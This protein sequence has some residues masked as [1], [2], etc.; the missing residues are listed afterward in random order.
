MKFINLL[1]KSTLKSLSAIGILLLVILF[2]SQGELKAQE[3]APLSPAERFVVQHIQKGKEANLEEFSKKSQDHILR[4][5]FV[6]NVLAGDYKLGGPI[7]RIEHAIVNDPLNAPSEDIPFAVWMTDC[8]FRSGVDFSDAKFAN[9]L[10]FEGSTFGSIQAHSQTSEQR[11]SDTQALF[12]GMHVSGSVVLS[13]AKFYVPLDF[14]YAQI[15]GQLLFDDVLFQAPGYADFYGLTTTYAP[16]FFRH[17]HF[18]GPLALT[19]ASLFELFLE[20]ITFDLSGFPANVPELNL[21][22]TQIT[23]DLSVTNT[24]FHSI[25]AEHLEVAG[26]ATFD[27]I[28]VSERLSLAHSRFQTLTVRDLAEWRRADSLNID[29]EGLSFEG[30]D[31]PEANV[32]DYAS[33]MLDLINSDR[34]KY[35]SPQPYLVLEKFLRSH[36]NPEKA[37]EV[38]IS[39]RRRERKEIAFWKRPGDWLLDMLVGYGRKP[40]RAALYLVA[41]ALVGVIVFRP[42]SMQLQDAKCDKSWYSPFWYS[43]DTLAPVIDLGQAKVWEPRPGNAWVRD[44]AQFQRIAGWILVPLILGAITGII[45]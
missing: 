43:L 38:Y 28:S 23:R 31:V 27:N 36:G 25:Q 41:L 33:R 17:D 11:S 6:E 42:S 14:T 21:D 29:F 20:D 9:G 2:F 37:D 30:V 15:A 45:K 35:Y 4:H 13:H 12:I 1:N 7:V 22:R 16:A 24:K 10:S 40:W 19:D 32:D 44:Y 8:E 34:N 18:T 26:P 5:E 3:T 39:M